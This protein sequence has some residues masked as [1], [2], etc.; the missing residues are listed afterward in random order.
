MAVNILLLM[1]ETLDYSI[2]E[3]SEYQRAAEG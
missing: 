1:E 3:I 2:F